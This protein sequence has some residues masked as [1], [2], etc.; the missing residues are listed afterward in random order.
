[1][2][3][4]IP[5]IGL[6]IV[7]MQLPGFS[8]TDT[9]HTK[10]DSCITL[11][12]CNLQS[13]ATN[14]NINLFG[15]WTTGEALERL[16][17][18]LVKGPIGFYTDARIAGLET[19]Y[20]SVK[21]NGLRPVG[22]QDDRDFSLDRMPAKLM[23]DATITYC[24][25]VIYHD[26]AP[27]GAV[28]L[29]WVQPPAKQQFMADVSFRNTNNSSP[30]TPQMTLTYGDTRGKWQFIAGYSINRIERL[31][32]QKIMSDTLSGN[33]TDEY[34]NL[35]NGLTTTIIFNPKPKSQWRLQSYFT[36][37]DNTQWSTSTM[38]PLTDG[39]I[40]PYPDTTKNQIQRILHSHSLL[41]THNNKRVVFSSELTF[42]Q[43]FGYFNQWHYS[44]SDSELAQAYVDEN[45]QN[46]QMANITKWQ[47]GRHLNNVQL[48]FE[49]GT[50]LDVVYRNYIHYAYSKTRSHRYWDN[51]SDESYNLSE[52]H[53]QVFTGIT[54]K[55]GQWCLT[56]ALRF[57]A[58]IAK[59]Q[60]VN[61]S[62]TPYNFMLNP[63]VNAQYTLNNHLS[64]FMAVSRQI[65]RAP[66][67]L[68]I[69]VDK[70]N[71][72]TQTVIRG[73]PDLTPSYA[74]NA[75]VGLDYINPTLGNIKVKAFYAI[76]ENV[77]ELKPAGTHPDYG[78][79]IYQ[80]VNMDSGRIW[81]TSLEY[82]HVVF[83]NKWYALRIIGLAN[84]LGS[85]VY[86]AYLQTTRRIN[87]QPIFTANANVALSLAKPRLALVGG[88]NYIGKAYSGARYYNNV[89]S[90]QIS[91]HETFN[92][93]ARIQ[94]HATAKLQFY[95]IG[96]NLLISPQT[97]HQGNIQVTSYS[98]RLFEGG[99]KFL[100]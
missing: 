58:D 5:A 39:S 81:G 51:L 6:L 41:F 30:L 25:S 32:T 43:H 23:Q 70:V 72:S 69:P 71:N 93:S 56:P 7:V 36:Q 10:P 24:P 53:P 54:L 59:Y 86:D 11:N 94:F 17:F 90:P 87:Q 3:K 62:E 22:G 15:H 95:L 75:S 45:Q 49:A 74:N 67:H 18:M 12:Q 37:T 99:A 31:N 98:G 100:F 42:A 29:T 50:F 27:I 97:W 2:V 89:L 55:A 91:H 13:R 57:G 61:T 44:Q 33:L 38:V 1:M 92:L 80:T 66:Y 8:Q 79:Q 16:P 40:N 28:S 14:A 34:K 65:T 82:D 46:T 47:W 21:I 19:Q 83:K 68:L 60:A 9:T 52:Y 63:S 78:Y 73:N 96:A 76:L 85:S 35:V 84:Y 77:F 88:F 48:K 20:Q 64:F 26:D 4:L